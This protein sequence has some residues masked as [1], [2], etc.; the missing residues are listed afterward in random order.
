MRLFTIGYESWGLDTWIR[1]LHDNG[2]RTVVDVREL[3]LSRRPGWSKRALA[4]RLSE[5]G[6]GYLHVKALGTPAPL[7]H[8]LRSGELPFS[9]FEPQ[10]GRMLDDRQEE[11][12]ALLLLAR[13]QPVALMCWEEDPARCHRSLVAKAMTPLA[14]EPIEITDIRRMDYAE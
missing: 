6:I 1:A 10:F 12:L 3:P 7:R 2:V 8:A 13:S 9:E 4:E 14:D 11:L 5:Q